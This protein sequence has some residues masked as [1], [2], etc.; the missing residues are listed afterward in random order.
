MSC[1]LGR[2]RG[3]RRHPGAGQG[4]RSAAEALRPSCG[5]DSARHWT[6]R[7]LRDGPPRSWG[8]RA[9]P[10]SLTWA[11]APPDVQRCRRGLGSGVGGPQLHA[12][13]RCCPSPSSAP[14]SPLL[15]IRR[16]NLKT[17]THRYVH[18]GIHRDTVPSG[19]D[20]GPTQVPP[21]KTTGWRHA[22]APAGR[23]SATRA[24]GRARCS[25]RARHVHVR[26]RT[27]PRRPAP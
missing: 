7:W 25:G 6:P 10:H 16:Q 19:Q 14:V 11:P 20:R 9:P 8:V 18:P 27:Q 13:R 3:L 5:T 24:G 12:G 15:G 1:P 21:Q 23:R 26:A 22:P 2:W 17:C 4:S